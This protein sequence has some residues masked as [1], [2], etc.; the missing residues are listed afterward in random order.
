MVT[1]DVVKWPRCSRLA[2]LIVFLILADQYSKYLIRKHLVIGQPIVLPGNWLRLNHVPN[3][4]GFSWWVPTPPEFL[5]AIFPFILLTIAF[6]AVPVFCRY[7]RRHSPSIWATLAFVCIAASGAS[8]FL[9]TPL[10]GYTTDFIQIYTSPS[11]NFAD[12][13]SYIGLSALGIELAGRR[14][15]RW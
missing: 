13:Y 9:D 5:G 8:H 12:V 6:A 14:Q 10:T 1:G 2:F 3:H 4:R 11:A 7:A 15:R